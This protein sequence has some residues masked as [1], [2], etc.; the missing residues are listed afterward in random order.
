MLTEAAHGA[1]SQPLSQFNRVFQRV[2]SEKPSVVRSRLHNR[3]QPLAF[4]T[5]MKLLGARTRL[6]LGRDMGCAKSSGK[7]MPLKCHD[8][9]ASGCSL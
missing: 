6:G 4:A 5:P 8:R 1:G 2:A 9:V 7:G 3:S